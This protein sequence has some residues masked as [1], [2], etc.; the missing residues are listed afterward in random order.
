M[1]TKIPSLKPVSPNMKSKSPVSSQQQLLQKLESKEESRPSEVDVS[2]PGRGSSPSH[3]PPVFLW[4]LQRSWRRG[5][6]SWNRAENRATAKPALSKESSATKVPAPA[7]ASAPASAPMPT[8]LER[9]ASTMPSTLT[10]ERIA[11]R[12]RWERTVK[13]FGDR[14]A[15]IRA[16]LISS[17]GG[18]LLYAP[19]SIAIALLN[20]GL[21]GQWEFSTDMLAIQLALFGVTYRYAIRED[22]STNLGDGVLLAFVLTRALANIHVPDTCNALPLDCGPPLGYVSSSMVQEAGKNFIDSYVAYT[23]ARYCLDKAF[24][25]GL[26]SRFDKFD[27]S[28]TN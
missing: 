16:A 24:S 14:I 6:E 1:K 18:S 26:L 3:H 27:E 25:S 12:Q 28:I 11:S 4:R 22:R 10:P 21:N 19:F 8:L 23:A 2:T 17:L 13:N 20:G 5:I 7:P 9:G 15:S